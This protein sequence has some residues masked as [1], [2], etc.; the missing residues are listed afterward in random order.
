MIVFIPCAGLGTRL[1]PL[2]DHCPKA[3]VKY[4]GK[5]LLVH[6]LERLCADG[7]RRFV[8]NLHHFPVM[9]QNF[10]EA[11]A[12]Q[13]DIEIYFSDESGR[14]LDTGG[15]LTHALPLF[16]GESEVLV[17]NV[18]VFDNLVP[19]DFYNTFIRKGAEALL[20]V[21]KR[22][23]GRFLYADADG[24]LAAWKNIKSGE[25]KGRAIEPQ[26]ESFAFSGIHL[27]KTDLI[28]AWAH[29]YGT[30][31]PFSVIDAYL[32]SAS[33]GKI[34][35]EEHKGG[36]W[37]DMGKIADFNEPLLENGDLSRC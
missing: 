2:T 23:S 5:P 30:N 16:A 36:Y 35:L 15:A 33:S 8:L 34:Y 29:R 13:N 6:L 31:R 1:R 25:V 4:Q 19:A 32:D 17:H 21:R 26:W 20:S 22:E 10:A 11:Y 28:A 14:L 24:H 37:K 18:D 27:I 9:L 3:L 7:Y 12:R